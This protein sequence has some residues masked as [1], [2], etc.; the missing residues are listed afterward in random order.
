VS[1]GVVAG[2]HPATAEAGAWA[3][4]EGGNAVDAAI[5]AV[6][7]SLTAESPLTGLGAGGYMLVHEPEGEAV[8]LDF[9]VAA[10]GLG[11]EP[12]SS[13]LVP[14]VIDFGGVTQVFNVG[15]ASCGVP[16]VPSGL[17]EAARRYGSM[18]LADLVRPGIEL[19]RT[20]L[21]LNRQ[22]ANLLKI[23]APVL[24][25]E[26]EGAAVYAP[27]GVTLT[28]G[29]LIAFP[30]LAETLE[31]FGRDG[32]DPFYR[33]DLA[34]AITTRVT[35][36]GGSLALEDL[37]AYRTIAREPLHVRYRDREIL[38]NPPPSSGGILIAFALE[39]IE[40]LDG[41]TEELVA[42]MEEAQN[43]RTRE[44]HAGLYEAGFAERFL[45]PVAIAAA[46]DR[47]RG[48]LRGDG[49]ERSEGPLGSTTHITAVDADGGC[50][51][52]TCSNGSGSGLFVPGT[53]IQINN[54]LGEDDLS[55]FGFHATAP[56]RRLPSMMSPTVVLGEHGLELGLGSGGSNRIRSAITQ[57][58]VRL[59][60]EG[61]DV[62]AAVEAPRL[63]YEAGIVHAEPGIDAG[64]LARLEARGFEVTRWPELNLYFGG[65]HAV[66][67]RGDGSLRGGADP[68]RGGA[69]AVA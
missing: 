39:L 42:I 26:P 38:T 49:R 34:S 46:A 17:A 30:E 68:R 21:E 57:T 56:G 27:R 31:R 67:R 66:G 4:R 40:R 47:C 64:A 61:L 48:L 58:I 55:P 5:A 3:M 29:E 63:H 9:F 12:R 8:L 20:G 11:S 15:G 7:A 16:G 28:A 43:V 22:Q 51:S 62:E 33:G 44:F 2:G 65:A 18:P 41:G 24:E 35:D 52:V 13:E 50:A 32:P 23:L 10:P 19:A 37:A 54:M 25:R 6:V 59:L 1:R 36:A 14:L 69:V 60:A 45:T 53:G